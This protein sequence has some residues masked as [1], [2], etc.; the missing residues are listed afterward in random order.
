MS[1]LL[2][3]LGLLLFPVSCTTVSRSGG[4]AEQVAD[5][6][7]PPLNRAVSVRHGRTGEV[8][9]FDAF[10]DALTRADVVFLGET[11]IDETT[12][13]VELAVYEGLLARRGGKVVLAME[14]FER[15]VQPALDDYLAGRIDEA[16]FL[17]RARPWKHYRTA[18]R[19][20]IEKARASGS[21]V[22]AS[23]FPR[24]LRRRVG[25]EG[26]QVLETLEGDAKREAPEELFPNTPAY[27]RRVD[28]AVRSHRAM[29]GDISGDDQRLYS[30]QSLWDNS[31]GE[32]CALALDEH[33]GHSVLH[34][35]GGFHSAYWD[36]TVRQLRLREPQAKVITV[37]IIPV[38]N[39]S[40]AEVGSVPTA[41]YVVFA[42]ARATDLNDGAWSVYV[43]RKQ[44]YRFHLPDGASD[45]EP[46]PLLI[47]LSDD[48]FTA[49]DG[50]DLW[51]DRLGGEVAIAVLAPPYPGIQAD[52]SK[53]GRWY[54]PDSFLSDI[55]A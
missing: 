27:W 33:P 2:C 9:S 55:G 11:H 21:P 15:D 5:W 52:L 29:M 26:P 18:Y 47:W 34:V 31:M 4:A 25:M 40:V 39:P 19:P 48:G 38:T 13:R 8:L 42:E 41:D 28:N 51:K 23:N 35:N 16:T 50:M 22:V 43:P 44:E 14:M 12:H 1:R 36:G 3:T 17:S 49:P 30:T 53:G 32:A 37:A 24:P 20:L 54:W 7:A 6:A 45:D 46:V 10:L